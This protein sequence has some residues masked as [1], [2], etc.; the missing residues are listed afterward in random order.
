MQQAHFVFRNGRLIAGIDMAGVSKTES[1]TRS[2]AAGH[3]TRS[4]PATIAPGTAATLA[5]LYEATVSRTQPTT[6]IS[7]PVR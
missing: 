7:L 1:V 2:S 5:C 3:G 4:V 6:T